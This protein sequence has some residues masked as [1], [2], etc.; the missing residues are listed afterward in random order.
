[1]YFVIII[2]KLINIYITHLV[3]LFTVY[4]YVSNNKFNEQSQVVPTAQVLQMCHWY[5]LR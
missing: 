1:M 2:T 4:R 5:L 3:P